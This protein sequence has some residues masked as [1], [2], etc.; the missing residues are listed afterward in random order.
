MQLCQKRENSKQK[1]RVF[2]LWTRCY[3][4]KNDSETGGRI[5]EYSRGSQNS[6]LKEKER[7]TK[8]I[9]KHLV[10]CK[11]LITNY[12]PALPLIVRLPWISQVSRIRNTRNEPSA[13][14]NSII[15]SG[16]RER[17]RERE[18]QSAKGIIGF[19][20]RYVWDLATWPGEPVKFN[21]A[22]GLQCQVSSHLVLPR[23]PR[24]KALA[25]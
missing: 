8:R 6:P 25:T 23:G 11:G 2:R 18:I 20:A 10:A 22:K 14:A 24:V 9:R 12:L 1:V 16:E 7:R 21:K 4:A 15:K 3:V 5:K 17:E 13:T 19:Q